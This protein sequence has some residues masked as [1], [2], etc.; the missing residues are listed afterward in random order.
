MRALVPGQWTELA[1]ESPA[2][3]RLD[4]LLP[5]LYPELSRSQAQRLIVEGHVKVNGQ[6]AKASQK[7]EAGAQLA[8]YLPPP[9]STELVPQAIPLE[10]LYQDEHL[11]VIYKPAGLVV[12]PAAGHADGTLVNALLHHL[13]DLSSSGGVGG[14]LRPGIVHRIDRNTS[15]VLLV[16]KTDAAHRALSQQ[17]KEHSIS[18]RYLGLCW[19]KLPAQGEW[20]EP[21]ARDPKDRKRMALVPGGR[22]AVTRFRTLAHWGEA[23]TLFEAELLTGRTHQIRVHFA[24][25]GYP[26][27]GDEVYGSAY[28][29]GRQQREAGLKILRK[30]CPDLAASLDTLEAAGRQFLHA[31]H[32]GF[33][34]PA[35]GARLE[36][37]RDLPEDLK[38][39][40]L[41][42][43]LCKTP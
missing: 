37:Q 15:G 35:T 34:H 41:E 14:E 5:R 23:A 38:K 11:A 12:H 33:T 6:A 39:T 17:F 2:A 4:S 26:L 31:A 13:G 18:R 16:T 3:A 19:G 22:R 1:L 42:W 20:N 29:S 43:S 10:I 27:A 9:K 28:R 25:H 40:V 32:L 8:V 21:I 7:L 24:A 36:F 30:R